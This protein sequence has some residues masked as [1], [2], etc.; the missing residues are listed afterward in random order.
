[1]V[2]TVAVSHGTKGPSILDNSKG[3]S[4]DSSVF[5]F[6]EMHCCKSVLYL[7]IFINILVFSC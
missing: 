3:E 4:S 1:M 5:L 6:I 2:E 7:T